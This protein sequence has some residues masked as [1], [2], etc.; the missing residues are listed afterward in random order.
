M[1]LLY[2]LLHALAKHGKAVLPRN[3]DANGA[4]SHLHVSNGLRD[5]VPLWLAGGDEVA[6]SKLH[7]LHVGKG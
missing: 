6:L 7:R 4:L 3:L 5:V 1:L 2:M